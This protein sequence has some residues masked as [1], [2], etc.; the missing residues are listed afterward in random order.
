MMPSVAS[1]D[2]AVEPGDAQQDSASFS[3]L[4]AGH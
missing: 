1:G 4:L 2:P 3:S